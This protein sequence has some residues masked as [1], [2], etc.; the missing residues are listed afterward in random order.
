MKIKDVLTDLRVVLTGL[1]AVQGALVDT[2]TNLGV[3]GKTISTGLAIIGI[4]ATMVQLRGEA[5][6]PT[7]ATSVV[8]P[9]VPEAI[10]VP[11]V[12]PKP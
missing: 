2:L 7:V 5:T 10:V 8:L 11:G 12:A 9:P 1:L 6:A 3:P 4:L